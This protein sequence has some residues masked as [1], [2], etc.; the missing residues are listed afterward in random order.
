MANELP[1]RES[2]VV[3]EEKLT[4]YLLNEQHPEGGSKAVFFKRFR[5]TLANRTEFE[6]VLLNLAHSG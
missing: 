4:K 3:P 1:N 2:A 5:Y 6:R